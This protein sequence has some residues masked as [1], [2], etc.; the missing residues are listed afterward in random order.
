MS[1]SN[2]EETGPAVRK[3]FRNWLQNW[4]TEPLLCAEGYVWEFEKRGYVAAGNFVPDFI[5]QY[6]ERV[7]QLTEDFVFAGS[8]VALAFQYYTHRRKMQVLGKEYYTENINKVALKVAKKVSEKTGAIFA[9]G[10][11]NT[12]VEDDDV[13]EKEALIEEIFREQLQ[14]NKDAGVEYVVA[15]TFSLAM[16]GRI[17][18]K[19]MDESVCP[20]CVQGVTDRVCAVT[21]ISAGERNGH[22]HC[23]DLQLV[24][25]QGA[26]SGRLFG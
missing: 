12:L 19:V 3:S 6:P 23:S 20:V 1:Q 17:A 10:L 11:C 5:L 13:M 8:D 24:Q 7:E 26:H 22:S 14:W 16:E 2:E 9:G 4:R 15:E 18:A 21:V 25:S